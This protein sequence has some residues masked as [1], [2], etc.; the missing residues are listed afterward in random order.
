M[1]LPALVVQNRWERVAKYPP[2]PTMII[3]FSKLFCLYDVAFRRVIVPHEGLGDFTAA[4]WGALD[5]E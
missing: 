3:E 1:L 2:D 4:L 5:R